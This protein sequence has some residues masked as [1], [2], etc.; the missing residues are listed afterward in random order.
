MEDREPI[1]LWI[2]GGSGAVAEEVDQIRWSRWFVDSDSSPY[3][4]SMFVVSQMDLFL[5]EVPNDGG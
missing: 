2:P 3:H 1:A 4:I 5:T